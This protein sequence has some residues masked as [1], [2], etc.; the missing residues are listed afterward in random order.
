MVT[1]SRNA[2]RF[3]VVIV[4]GGLIGCSIAREVAGRG[5]TVAVVERVQPGA[6]AS[7][8]AAGLLSPQVEAEEPG[9]FFDLALESRALHARWAQE[10]TAETG[11]D[12]GYRRCGILRCSFREDSSLVRSH[13][14][15]MQAG[16]AIE[17]VDTEVPWPVWAGAG[18]AGGRRSRTRRRRALSPRP[19]GPLGLR[20][21]VARHQ[22]G[23]TAVAVCVVAP[24]PTRA[25]GVRR[26][27]EASSGRSGLRVS[28][29][30][31]AGTTR[32]G[33]EEPAARS[34]SSTWVLAPR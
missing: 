15:Q 21:G 19:P 29:T 13:E 1:R 3:D 30:V 6:E 20:Y 10:L 26:A 14:W 25:S 27:S 22:P 4:G 33:R 31:T 11:S 34:S 16:L 28:E 17:P 7:S 18:T 2:S 12:V 23:P 8:A 24:T 32:S 5:R 9:A